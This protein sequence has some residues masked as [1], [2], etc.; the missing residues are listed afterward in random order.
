MNFILYSDINDSSIH[1]TPEL[2]DSSYYFVL[3]A[4]LP[5]FGTLGQVH[6]VHSVA[7]VDPVYRQLLAA[8]QE[9]VFLSFTRPQKTPIDLECPTVCVVVWE[10]DSIPDEQ[11]NDDPRQ[12]WTRMLAAHRRAITL[13]SHTSRAI[14]RAM[15][16]DFPVL[17]LPAPVWERFTTLRGQH[18]NA[19]VNAGTTLTVNGCIF[20]S[21]LLN[22][23]PDNLLPKPLTPQEQAELE[24]RLEASRPPP[25]TLK[26]RFVIARHYLRLWLLNPDQN[27]A[28]PVSRVRF[29]QNWYW[30]GI[31]DLVPGAVHEWLGKHLPDIAGPLPVPLVIQPPPKDM[32]ESSPQARTTVDGVVYVS[33]FRP[34]DGHKNWLQI[35]TAFCAAFRDTPDATLVMKFTHSDIAAVYAHL[36]TPLAQLAPFSCR[37]VMIQGH[38]EDLE[39]ARLCQAASFYVNAS[40]SEGLCLPLM[41]FMACG[42]PAIAPDHTAMQDYIDESVAFV[43][44]SGVEAS[45]WPH[46][47]RMLFRTQRYRPDWGS[48]KKAYESSYRMAT[49]RPEDYQRMSLAAAERMHDCC[50]MSALQKRV[51]TFFGLQ[52]QAGN[53]AQV[54]DNASC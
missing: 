40:H 43:V 41:E 12:D 17:E 34:T 39:Y 11:W 26:R 28:S 27:P 14:H 1:Q 2:P 5:L 37:V 49:T 20:D 29:L 45:T 18:V 51:A 3:K 7:E 35:L 30:E 25:L 19:P 52:P 31:H 50:E 38:L 10:Y 33:V 53:I 46:D 48:L 47:P 23:H 42:K 21:R 36:M 24:A 44:G 15:G 9:S 16:E 8:G 6:V 32:P 13:S 4:C 54:T 22:L